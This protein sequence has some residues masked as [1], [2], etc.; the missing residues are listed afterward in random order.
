MLSATALKGAAGNAARYYKT[1]DYYVKG[2]EER[3]R[4]LGKGAEGLGMGG[5]IA[6]R[7]LA[8][9]LGGDLP[10]APQTAWPQDGTHRL[11]WDFT[12]N[13]PK[14]VSVA[15]LIGGDQ[16]LIEA[17]ERAAK[18]GFEFL[19]RF[20]AVRERVDGALQ[21][22]LTGNAI[23]AQFTEFSS[24]ALEAHLHT[25]TVIANATYDHKRGRWY[26][27]ES[28][29]MFVMKMAAGQVYRSALAREARA[30][31][32]DI[33]ADDRTGLF[34][35][36]RVSRALMKKHSTRSEDISNYV[37]EHR[38]KGA[39]GR[40]VAAKLTRADK[41]KAVLQD[42]LKGWR[43]DA[44]GYL[45]PLIDTVKAARERSNEPLQDAGKAEVA[46]ATWFGLSHATANEAVV[47]HGDVVRQ[48]L[49]VSVG[50]AVL[51]DVE[52]KLN[53]HA[54]NGK[55]LHALDQTGGRPIYQ[56]RLAKR[57]L[58]QE[59]RFV[60]LLKRGRDSL[61]P[62]VSTA[63]ADRRLGAFRLVRQGQ[64][65]PQRTPLSAEQFAAGRA[66][67]SSRNRFHF[68]QGVGGAGK[69]TLV[70][71]LKAA[72]PLRQHVAIAP[73]AN[74]AEDLGR[75][76][77]IKSMT[78]ARMLITGMRELTRGAI[79][80]ADEASMLETP[81]AIRALELAL[82][83]GYRVVV[84]GD[85]AQL[86][87]V[88]QGKPHSIAL[89]VGA[90][91]AELKESRRHKTN[92]VKAAVASARAG[93][94]R[95]FFHQIGDKIYNL[96]EKDLAAHVA[97]YWASRKDREKTRVLALDNKLRQQINKEI[98]ARLIS[99]RKL[100]GPGADADILTSLPMTAAQKKL[101]SMYKKGSVLV[102]NHRHER[103]AIE[104]G[105]RFVVVGRM[106]DV[107]ELE[108]TH[109][110]KDK[111][112]RSIMWSPRKMPTRAFSV[113]DVKKR[114]V[115]KGDVIQWRRNVPEKRLRNGMNGRVV[116]V[117]GRNARI[118]FDGGRS[119]NVNLDKLPWWD[120]GY[121]LTVHKAQGAE[122]PEA[123]LA[124]P[125]EANGLLD[126]KSLYTAASRAQYSIS[127]WTT[128][129]KRLAK[130]L[131]ASPGGKTSSLEAMRELRPIR[132]SAEAG[133]DRAANDWLRAERSG[134]DRSGVE[135]L[136]ER[137][138]GASG[139]AIKGGLD[140]VR[141]SIHDDR[142]KDASRAA[143]LNAEKSIGAEMDTG[144]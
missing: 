136:L 41:A 43:D 33:D 4:W 137:I 18:A 103:S 61:R 72:A 123:I 143:G 31:G 34:E 39:R 65:G 74:P 132:S 76:A 1:G 81:G 78:V 107:L 25:H 87:A 91:S 10:G 7:D 70:R 111:P 105:D 51:E 55:Y 116:D 63:T 2:D 56:G 101:P 40:A 108:Q 130:T 97:E 19:E 54:T 64:D 20:V 126:Q 24:R 12:F 98:R 36:A 92:E 73:A 3:S 141:N 115:R 59:E 139:D 11:G 32:Y 125:A 15:A 9:V 6:G 45:Q 52:K 22:R 68:I 142:E 35:L 82:A 99:E 110:E 90:K 38:L 106:G 104:R 120:H 135:S 144:R 83:K 27:V 37:D 94:V 13:A 96:D 131:A 127:L 89:K 102:F 114:D 58:V 71:A 140:A 48:A 100:T 47:E 128:D 88:G 77:R 14:S 5:E 86:P 109:S 21:T 138:M 17:H 80:Y 44:K 75:G 50:E 49:K 134:A 129:S 122:Y 16:R 53:E 113:F 42:L 124:A 85:E 121:A 30:L 29:P 46:R 133:Q 57:S 84:M 117:N 79:I 69:S 93:D 23:A 26:A 118:K 67:L 8:A 112:L 95:G 28:R 119:V 60:E 66:V 62:I